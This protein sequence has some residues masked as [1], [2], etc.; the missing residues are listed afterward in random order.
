MLFGNMG[1]AVMAEK[2]RRAWAKVESVLYS[3]GCMPGLAEMM[4]CFSLSFPFLSLP[5]LL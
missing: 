5:L 3:P 1:R 2:M 4:L